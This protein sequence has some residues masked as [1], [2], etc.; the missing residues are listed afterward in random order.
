MTKLISRVSPL[1]KAIIWFTAKPIEQNCENYKAIDYLL[2]GLLTSSINA[3]PDLLSHVLIGEQFGD[4]LYI[5]VAC[6]LSTSE[7]KHFLRLIENKVTTE[8]TILVIDDISKF[9]EMNK[10][11]NT[12]LKNNIVKY[13]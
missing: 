9:D 7:F 1:T 5:F 11:F 8:N 10:L 3:N 13:Y 12:S 2:N 4:Q 6:D